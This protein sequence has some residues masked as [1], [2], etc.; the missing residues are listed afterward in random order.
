MRHPAAAIL[1]ASLALCVLGMVYDE[2]TINMYDENDLERGLDVKDESL[3]EVAEKKKEVC[4]INAS[5]GK[6]AEN[7]DTVLDMTQYAKED[8]IGFFFF[9]NLEDLETPGWE[10]IVMK[11]LPYKRLITQSRWPKFLGWKHPIIA[12][13]CKTVYYFDV[14]SAP[15]YKMKYYVE[16]AKNYRSSEFGMAQA[17]H[18]TKKVDDEWNMIVWNNKDLKENVDVSKKWLKNQ[19]DYKSDI[20]S[21]RNDHIVYDPE[22]VHF[23]KASEFFWERYSLELDSWRDQPLWWYSLHHFNITPMV[24]DPAGFHFDFTRMGFGSHHYVKEDTNGTKVEME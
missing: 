22:S 23:R 6:S 1:Q 19:P 24:L 3:K 12:K 2:L 5:F 8:R 11:D 9:T 16:N 15:N 4:F 14:S 13:M 7:L 20:K 21:W 18:W 10:K 17:N